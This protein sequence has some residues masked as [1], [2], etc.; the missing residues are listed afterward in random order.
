MTYG[1]GAYTEGALA[2]LVVS[3]FAAPRPQALCALGLDGDRVTG[4]LLAQIEYWGSRGYV[5]IM[6][7]QNDGRIPEDTVREA[8]SILETW[9]SENGAIGFSILCKDEARARL[10][11][12]Y[13]F[14]RKQI[15]LTTEFSPPTTIQL[16]IEQGAALTIT[17]EG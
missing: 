2:T 15:H 7:V 3:N 6:Q 17:E 4:H 9:G 16:P 11:R 14:R 1:G 13:G 10:F 8:L 5:G 12:R